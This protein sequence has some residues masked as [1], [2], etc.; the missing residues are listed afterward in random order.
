MDT[1][2]VTGA[3]RGMGRLVAQRLARRG[4]AVLVTDIDAQAA[5]ETARMIGPNAW[6]MS[7]DVRNP[8]SHRAAARA[9]AERGPLKVWVNNAG[10]L[11]ADTGWGHSDADVTL[12]VEVNLLGLMW[13]ARAAVEAMRTSGGHIINLGSMSSLTP[14]PGLGVYGASKMGVLG[15]S[16]SLQGDL[17][18]AGIPIKVS[19]ICPD[20]VDTD[21]VKQVEGERASALLFSSRKLLGPEKVADL[22]VGLLDDYKL[23]LVYPRSRGAL[24]RVLAPFP[25]LGL[26]LLRQYRR[27]GERNRRRRQ[28]H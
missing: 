27:L 9:A 11:R 16:I 4:L 6:A 3:G 20:A 5:E 22:I 17:Q 12:Q 21:M 19:V 15:Y 2:V 14:T 18:I 25:E 23:V 26:M 28:A 24:A 8:D 1:A 10:V 13:G 7:Q